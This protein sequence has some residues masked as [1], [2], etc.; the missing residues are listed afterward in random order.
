M[1]ASLLECRAEL[2]RTRQLGKCRQTCVYRQTEQ[3]RGVVCA[4]LLEDGVELGR[5]G[6]SR[7]SFDTFESNVL[8]VLR[9]MIDAGVVGGGWV[10]APAG[11]YAVGAAG[12]ARG[13]L[14]TCQLDL[15]LHF[16]CVPALP[17]LALP[18]TICDR[19]LSCPWRAVLKSH[20][21]E[22]MHRHF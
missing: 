14:S 22:T 5:L 9:Y 1:R 20:R 11:K 18:M 3:T 7:V 15:H 12:V 17:C 2:R 8:F 13:K 19:H 4:A 10:S 6:L 21:R 16:R